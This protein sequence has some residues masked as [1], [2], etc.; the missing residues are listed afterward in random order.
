MQEMQ[1]I[2]KVFISLPIPYLIV[3]GLP[4]PWESL[5]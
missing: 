2:G 5:P 4:K 3:N 1:Q